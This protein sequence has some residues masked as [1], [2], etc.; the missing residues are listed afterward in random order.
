MNAAILD[1][2]ATEEVKN[3]LL[4]EIAR[5]HRNLAFSSAL[6]LE[7]FSCDM[8][9][10]PP[11]GLDYLPFQAPAILGMVEN[12]RTL[13]ADEMGT[14]KTIE[15][16]GLINQINP[17]SV[18]IVCPASLKLNWEQEISKWYTGDRETFVHD[19]Q[20]PFVSPKGL[21]ILNYDFLSKWKDALQLQIWPLVIADEGH[22]LKNSKSQRCRAFMK[23]PSDRA[24]IATGTPLLNRPEELW[25]LLKYLWPEVFS[26]W[27]WFVTVYC[28]ASKGR[29]GMDTSGASNLQFLSRLLKRMGMIRRLKRDVMPYL[30]PKERQIIEV[31]CE[32]ASMFAAEFAA[33]EHYE[34]SRRQLRAMEEA[35]ALHVKDASFRAAMAELRQTVIARFSELSK[36]RHD[37]AVFKIP[38]VIAHL[39]SAITEHKVVV[40]CHHKDVANA[41]R[42]A[43]ERE[44]IKYVGGMSQTAKHS[45]VHRFQNDADCTLFIGS[46]QAAGVGLTLTA[47][48]HCVFAEEDWVPGI[49]TQCEDRLHR[50]G[51]KDSVF[52]QHLVL[53][54][55]IDAM[56]AHKIVAKQRIADEA[57]GDTQ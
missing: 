30:P 53:H 31:P 20:H 35:S 10:S 29:H 44:S 45:A 37:T 22:L 47:A 16:I 55:S 3:E 33:F 6:S 1:R 41:L 52:V 48:S 36:L 46:I 49:V 39:Q 32:D 21:H 54:G 11:N 2:Y 17:E 18:L 9:L 40:F 51:Q 25:T 23:I 7:G 19:G 14:G 24:V 56:M 13:L 28:D 26:N 34:A 12:R 8:P 42:D 4:N 50:K 15:I 57:L 5:Q 38:T 27:H 43:F